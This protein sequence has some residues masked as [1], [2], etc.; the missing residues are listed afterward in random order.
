MASKEEKEDDNNTKIQ[1]AP[2]NN[3]NIGF[4]HFPTAKEMYTHL[5]S[6]TKAGGEFVVRN[7]VGVI[8][9][10]SPDASLV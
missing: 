10:I 3:L 5:C 6:I 9:D 4:P 1:C 2:S 7:F 8:E